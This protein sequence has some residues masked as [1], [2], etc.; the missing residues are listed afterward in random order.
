MFNLSNYPLLT[1]LFDELGVLTI[2]SDMS[3]SASVSPPGSGPPAS[4][5][6]GGG[7]PFEWSSKA[8]F[9]TLG[10]LL[11]PSRWRLFGGILWFESDA[12][13]YLAAARAS[14]V[15]AQNGAAAQTVGE[16]LAERGYSETFRVAYFYPMVA[17]IWSA[18][19]GEVDGFSMLAVLAF[20][21]NH[22]MLQRQRP[23]WRTPKHRSADYVARLRSTLPEGSLVLGEK[24][25]AIATAPGGGAAGSGA[26]AG[27]EGNGA[28]AGAGV[29]LRLLG[30]NGEVLA[31]GR[32]FDAVVLACHAYQSLAIVKHKLTALP[33]GQ[34]AAGAL[35]GALSQFGSTPN[36]IVVHSDVA[37][38]PRDRRCWAAWNYIAA[39]LP[40]SRHAA[41]AAGGGNGSGNGRSVTVTY[42]ANALQA[43]SGPPGAEDLFV[44]LNPP[45][46]MVAPS[47]VIK[48]CT[49]HH[50]SLS[51]DAVKA[52]AALARVQGTGGVFLAGAWTDS[53]FHEDGI[54][55]GARV[56]ELLGV[57][58][59]APPAPPSP[60]MHVLTRR[61]V[62]PL[63]RKA[64]GSLFV[65]GTTRLVLPSGEEMLFG[66]G[67]R[68][69]PAA[70]VSAPMPFGESNN[71]SWG[72]CEEVCV[73][74]THER[75]LWR[76]IADP[77]MGLAE[78]FIEGEV[79]IAPDLIDLFRAGLYN[80]S[81]ASAGHD[82]PLAVS[83][84][85]LSVARVWNR[86]LYRLTPNSLGE[87]SLKNISAHYDLSNQ[88]FQTFLDPTMTYSSGIYS[89]AYAVAPLGAPE[90]ELAN[91]HAAQLAK[92][93]RMAEMLDIGPSDKV[94]EI[95]FG[96]G[97]CAIRTVGQ[98]GC[99]WV[100]LTL[101]VEQLE[102]AKARVRAAG[103][104]AKITLL[105]M[106]YRD[107]VK[108]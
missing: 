36:E 73:R 82:S 38:M 56:S 95:G 52:R 18:P 62:L 98:R 57:S 12:R 83:I 101:S 71:G 27:G 4:A 31:G 77:G 74:V 24:V 69:G 80:A 86:L 42:Y 45:P 54:R 40:G 100:G 63:L 13:S 107:V 85:A 22:F 43:V 20:L 48:A 76:L 32:E 70:G 11:Q 34:A 89:D 50:P 25:A 44:T 59:P 15:D 17:S 96:W 26:A 93:D 19:K 9:P 1:R 78:A 7:A 14:S 39:D 72:G 55:S 79:V 65:S 84:A 2:A 99:E 67:G 41:A 5:G 88:M 33:G 81:V 21:D 35:S 108:R 47:K 29:S 61:L 49:M 30:E 58:V 3:L 28:G 46:G 37:A 97:S 8:P 6:S 92:L 87:G 90:D 64:L 102:E 103:L 23:R 91:L 104:E 106:D 105:L 60:S 94:L 16:W 75:A 53:G 68:C 51:T 10:S 66:D